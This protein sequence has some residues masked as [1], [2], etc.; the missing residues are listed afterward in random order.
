MSR[1]V[2]IHKIEKVRKIWNKELT[3]KRNAEI[4]GMSRNHASNMAKKFGLL[5]IPADKEYRWCQ[6][7]LVDS[8]SSI[9]PNKQRFDGD[10]ESV[11]L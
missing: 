1:G 2:F 7:N 4:L 5:F 11:L 6:D 10:Q 3:V 9:S 8:G